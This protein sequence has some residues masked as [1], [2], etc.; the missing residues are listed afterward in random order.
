MRLKSFS[1]K[2]MTE[3][4]Q[5]VRDALGEDA[6]IVATR[7]EQGGPSRGGSVSVT[8][9]IDPSFQDEREEHKGFGDMHDLQD[10]QTDN[11]HDD[12]VNFETHGYGSGGRAASASREWLQYDDESENAGIAEDITDTLLR[13]GVTEDVMDHVLS[14]ATVVGLESSG[15]ALM[16]AIEHL[17]H[18]KP[19]PTQGYG[20]AIMMV[21]TPGSG[22]TLA[23]AKMAARGVINGLKVGV[24]STDTV[25]A[26]GIEQ[27]RNFTDLLHIDLKTA[28]SVKDLQRALNELSGFD[29]VIIDTAGLNP[30]NKDDVKSLARMIGVGGVEPYAVIP[31]GIDAEESAEMARVF[32][33]VGAES[34]IATRIDMTRRLGGIL[35]ASHQGGLALADASNTPKVADGLMKMTP[36]SLSKLLMPA[37][38]REMG[39]E[40]TRRAGRA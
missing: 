26:G 29:Q 32:S 39:T 17:F 3:A 16:A 38:F 11:F 22:K 21:G 24:V 8:A 20:K 34:M 35:S 2:S 13:H 6:I 23:A 31:A 28:E 10:R 33:T 27:L 4:M 1:A 14:C 7:E 15:I 25:R 37:A 40:R 9:A 36:K 12:D 18:F 19:L 5:M 30:F